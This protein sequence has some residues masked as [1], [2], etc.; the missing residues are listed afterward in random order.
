MAEVKQALA[1]LQPSNPLVVYRRPETVQPPSSHGSPVDHNELHSPT[2]GSEVDHSSPLLPEPASSLLVDIS[3]SLSMLQAIEPLEPSPLEQSASNL[4]KDNSEPLESM[5]E[6]QVDTGE[7]PFG[8]AQGTQDK[9]FPLER[10]DGNLLVNRS[11]LL[12]PIPEMQLNESE[13]PVDEP[14]TRKQ[15]AALFGV[16][17]STIVSWEAEGR[18]KQEGWQRISGD[19]RPCLYRALR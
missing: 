9:A 10:S 8:N 6:V 13:P 16:T 1:S 2:V 4:L 7:P 18:L 19:S 14:V 3:E 5:L 11:K 12:K 15:L 17:V